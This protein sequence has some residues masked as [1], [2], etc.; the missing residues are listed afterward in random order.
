LVTSL[1][2]GDEEGTVKYEFTTLVRSWMDV[3]P[4]M[5]DVKPD[6]DGNLLHRIWMETQDYV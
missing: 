2:N 5:D 1:I 4:D 6:M 3:K